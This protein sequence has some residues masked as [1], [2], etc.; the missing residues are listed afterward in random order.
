MLK[1]G[2][3]CFIWVYHPVDREHHPQDLQK[4]KIYCAVRKITSHLPIELQHLLYISMMGP[5]L[6][7]QMINRLY[8]RNPHRTWHEK[9]QNL[10]DTFSPVH[11]HRHTEAEVLRWFS[12]EGFVGAEVAYK[13]HFGFGARGNAHLAGTA[14]QRTPKPVPNEQMWNRATLSRCRF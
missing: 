4:M 13:E 2:G 12:E 1:D 7:K 3:R 5:F 6:T 10:F 14:S 9:M 8:G 11:Q